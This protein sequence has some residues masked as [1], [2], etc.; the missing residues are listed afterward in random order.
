MKTVIH[1]EKDML[2]LIKESNLKNLFKVYASTFHKVRSKNE[3]KNAFKIGVMG[4]SGAGKSTFINSLCQKYVCETGGAGG[5]TREVQLIQGKMGEMNVSLFD[6]P[7]I[8]ENQKWGDDYLK[9]YEE[10]L[11]DLDLIF[12]LVKI[13]D[14]ANLEDEEFYQKH[15][16]NSNLERKFI[17]ILSQSDKAEPNREWSYSRFEPSTKQKETILRNRC[18]IYRQF[19]EPRPSEIIPLASSFEKENNHLQTYNFDAIFETIVF[20]LNRKI[21]ISVEIPLAIDW[22]LSKR[23]LKDDTDFYTFL[24]KETRDSLKSLFDG[25]NDLRS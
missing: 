13:D 4:K 16:K 18:R 7:G 14:R 12:W 3:A 5:V 15:I 6:F 17:F 9:L 20:Y 24:S 19:N 10:S 8:A 21:D 1:L 23:E 25:V 2:D 11:G 22:E